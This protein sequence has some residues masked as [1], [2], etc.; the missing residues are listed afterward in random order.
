MTTSPTTVVVSNPI[1]MF[2]GQKNS[3]EASV[4]D[5]FNQTS[6]CIADAYLQC[7]KHY[8][9]NELPIRLKGPAVTL[10]DDS[11]GTDVTI[12]VLTQPLQLPLSMFLHM[13]CRNTQAHEGSVTVPLEIQNCAPSRIQG[14]PQR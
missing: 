9:C 5:Y 13:K 2:P 7:G 8:F 3:F 10:S 6:S 1:R 14:P 4:I 12:E 11:V